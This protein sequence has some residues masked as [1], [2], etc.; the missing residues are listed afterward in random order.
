MR[1]LSY[2]NIN[3]DMHLDVVTFRLCGCDWRGW[4]QA[5]S[6]PRMAG[7]IDGS[8]TVRL[9]NAPDIGPSIGFRDGDHVCARRAP[10]RPGGAR[11]LY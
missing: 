8:G 6:L 5:G 1:Q 7:Q 11:A 3:I 9:P 10:H 4:Q 2:Y